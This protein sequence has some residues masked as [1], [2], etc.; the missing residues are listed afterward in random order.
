MKFNQLWGVIPLADAPMASAAEL[1]EYV[2]N[3]GKAV[4]SLAAGDRM[5]LVVGIGLAAKSHNM[6]VVHQVE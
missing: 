3:W 4:G 6:L 2:C 1:L 5:V